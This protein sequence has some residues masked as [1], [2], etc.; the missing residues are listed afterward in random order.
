TSAQTHLSFGGLSMVAPFL[1]AELIGGEGGRLV[2]T[3]M[4]QMYRFRQIL[5]TVIVTLAI[6]TEIDTFCNL[7]NGEVAAYLWNVLAEYSEEAKEMLQKR[8]QKLL[9]PKHETAISTNAQSAP[10]P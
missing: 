9:S 5:R 4:I 3:R 8:Y 6:A 1:V 7:G 2:N 10:A